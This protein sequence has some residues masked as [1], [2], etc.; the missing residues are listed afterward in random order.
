MLLLI[1]KRGGRVVPELPLIPEP[2]IDDNPVL[3][4]T[5]TLQLFYKHIVNVNLHYKWFEIGILLGVPKL[6]LQSL[7]ASNSDNSR[8]I[9][10]IFDSW[11]KTDQVE[12]TW[13]SLFKEL[14]NSTIDKDILAQMKLK[15]I[16]ELTKS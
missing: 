4:Q 2:D 13:N 11:E 8:A 3:H 15:I 6:K 10:D 14:N 12:F 1:E 9:L 7:Q 5:P 16:E